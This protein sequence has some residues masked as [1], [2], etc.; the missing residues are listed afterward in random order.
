MASGGQSKFLAELLGRIGVGAPSF[1]VVLRGIEVVLKAIDHFGSLF[2]S[3]D[4]ARDWK[5]GD[6][7]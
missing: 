3:K 4:S 2:F 6:S 1:V 7:E 5:G